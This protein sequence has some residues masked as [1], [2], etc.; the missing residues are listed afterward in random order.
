MRG[1]LRLKT[2]KGWDILAGKSKLEYALKGI[3]WGIIKDS[4]YYIIILRKLFNYIVIVFTI[5]FS[6]YENPRNLHRTQ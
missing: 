4:L 5:K 1:G 2:K 3:A 6:V